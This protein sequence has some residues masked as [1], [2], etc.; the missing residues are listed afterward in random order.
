MRKITIKTKE[1]KNRRLFIARLRSER[2][3]NQLLVGCLRV[4]KD[5]KRMNRPF[6]P[7]L[8]FEETSGLFKTLDSCVNEAGAVMVSYGGA[9]SS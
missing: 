1:R 2:R 3:A 5:K 6:I 9:S 4:L 7:R 8:R